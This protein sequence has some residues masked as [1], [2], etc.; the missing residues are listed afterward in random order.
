MN[1]LLHCCC[2]PCL[3]GSYP[4]LEKEIG[5]VNTA[6]FWENPN[7][8]PY[9]EYIQRMNSFIKMS[10][11]YGLKI[12]KGDV[13]YGLNRF[14]CELNGKYDSSRCETCYRL[15]LEAT[16]KKAVE[17]GFESFSTTL[18]ISPYQNHELLQK[19]GNEAAD[20]YKVKFLYVDFRPGFKDS[21]EII[22]KYELYKQKYCGCIFSEYDR[23]INDKKAKNLLKG[24]NI[25]E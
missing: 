18:L 1:T 21:H 16:A 10:E 24:T 7:I 19:V 6:V 20:K 5:S 9:F 14:L 23:Y 2:G 11:I 13:E 4:I 15:R 25:G 8:H 22:R 12:Y 3:G 17:K